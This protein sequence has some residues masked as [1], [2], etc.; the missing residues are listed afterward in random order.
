MLGAEGCGK[1]IL[2]TVLTKKYQTKSDDGYFLEAL[3]ADANEF[4]NHNWHILTE[5]QEWPPATPPGALRHFHWRL[6]FNGSSKDIVAGD[7]AGEVFRAGFGRNDW[8]SVEA[9]E[10]KKYISESDELMLLINL[11]DIINEQDIKRKSET[12]WALKSCLD[13]ARTNQISHVSIVFTQADRYEAIFAECS[14]DVRKVLTRYLPQ[15]AGAYPDIDIRRVAAVSGV[16]VDD[17]PDGLAIERP[18]VHETAI[19]STGISQL[20]QWLSETK[21]SKWYKLIYGVIVALFIL[22]A[23]A[24]WDSP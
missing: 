2:L 7:F 1:T 19:K 8:S 16:T 11:K 9:Q 22:L 12:E 20:I 4:T 17:G 23:R 21:T 18:S 5:K 15:I 10:L 14:D 13:F 3:S 24:C 6:H